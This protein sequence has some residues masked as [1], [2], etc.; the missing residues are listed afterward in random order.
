VGCVEACSVL[1][2]L[3]QLKIDTRFFWDQSLRIVSD[4]FSSIS[5]TIVN[6]MK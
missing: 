5:S 4:A 2:N 3:Q 1:Q 6:K